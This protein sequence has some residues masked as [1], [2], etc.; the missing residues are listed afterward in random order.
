MAAAG[1]GIGVAVQALHG[2]GVGVPVV[3][4]IT[5]ARACWYTAVAWFA[6]VGLLETIMGSTQLMGVGVGVARGVP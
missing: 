6:G 4:A 5:V 2:N 1:G 3:A